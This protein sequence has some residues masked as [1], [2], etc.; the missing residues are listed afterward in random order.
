M[1]AV[2]GLQV[3]YDGFQVLWG[4]DVTVQAGR[5]VALLGPNGAGKSTVLNAVSGF[6]PRTAGT[7]SFCGERIER[8]PTH[9]IVARG[10]VHV[11]ERHR[12][13]PYLSV[14]DNLLLGAWLPEAKRRRA[15]TLESVYHLF[16]RLRERARQRAHSLSGGEQQMLAIGRGL[17][18]QPKLLMLDEPFLGLAPDMV[19]H[20]AEIIVRLRA[21]GVTILFIEQNVELA[22]SLADYAYVLE[23]GRVAVEGT[24]SELSE[25]DEIRRVYFG[26]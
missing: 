9:R 16:P 19:E 17:M 3:G 24:S 26:L 5:I 14:H 1:L 13:F 22:L 2:D 25:H 23:S 7:V 12:V 21:N 10:L 18:A 20:I 11:L 15:A 6:V 8:L 4:V